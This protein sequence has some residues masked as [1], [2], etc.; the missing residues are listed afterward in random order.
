M[1]TIEQT[2]LTVTAPPEKRTDAFALYSMIGMLAASLGALAAGIPTML[3]REAGASALQSL[4]VMFVGYACLGLV[5]A[6]VYGR[7]S[8]RIEGSDAHALARFTGGA[9]LEKDG[10]AFAEVAAERVPEKEAA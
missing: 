9:V 2:I 7:L 5:I 3:Q 6:T 10:R 8:S 1:G 4:R